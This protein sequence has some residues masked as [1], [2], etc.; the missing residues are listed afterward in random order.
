M[1]SKPH[2]LAPPTTLESRLASMRSI[3]KSTDHSRHWASITTSAKYLERE[4]ERER[5]REE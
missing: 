2:P 1:A 5:E 4:R 3:D